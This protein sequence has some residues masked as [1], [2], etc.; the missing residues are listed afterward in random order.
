MEAGEWTRQELEERVR[1][2]APKLA[3]FDCDG[4][5]WG[6]DAGLGFMNWTLEQG[7]V[8][9]GTADWI[10]TRHRAYRAG[11]VSE[12][13]ICGEMV[14]I[15]AGLHEDELQRVAAQYVREFVQPQVFAE[16]QA[17]VEQLQGRGTEIWAV[18]S[19]NKW[20]IVEGV[21]MFGIPEERV[22]AAEVAV[23]DGIITSEIVDV[24]TD[25]GKAESLRRVGITRP[26]VVFGNSVHDLAMLEIAAHAFPINPS[27]AL[28]EA[29]A[30]N[31]WGHYRPAAAPGAFSDITGL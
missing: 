15:Y 23:K 4:T 13:Q 19:T 24:P 10:D 1:E 12:V 11:E 16:I 8:S 20:V 7:I 3:V 29:A 27:P 17:L 2:I 25:E 18:S 22:L 5:L 21:G 9:R 30:R 26:D 6:G 31:G 14:Q 28:L